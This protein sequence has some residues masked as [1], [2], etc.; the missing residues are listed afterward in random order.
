VRAARGGDCAGEAGASA[1]LEY[2]LAGEIAFGELVCER[3]RRRPQD[4]AVRKVLLDLAAQEVVLLLAG[5]DRARVEN[6][7]FAAGELERDLLE[8]EFAVGGADGVNAPDYSLRRLCFA[9]MAS[10]PTAPRGDGDA[11]GFLEAVDRVIAGLVFRYRPPLVCCVRIHRWFD[12][13]WLEFSGKGR[14][15][16]DA[17][18]PPSHP[19]VALD[20]FRQ[21]QLTFPPFTPKR[22]AAEHHWERCDNG[23]YARTQP[24]F[25]VHR[26]VLRRS[27]NNLQRRIADLADPALFVWFSS[28]SEQDTRGSILV[29]IVNGG[30]T[31]PWFASMRCEAT[32]W[33]LGEVKGLGR[34]EV[35]E[36]LQHP[37]GVQTTA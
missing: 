1:E 26:R 3:E 2:A 13:R 19:N 12:H 18:W 6:A 23:S 20:E 27:S 21:E 17:G 37:P 22:V 7:P 8:R 4:A 30:V 31:I 14:V 10:F 9:K 28:T 36:L 15:F 29:Y 11:S 34:P 5:D 35:Q 25:L 33:T 16:F 24:R 32:T